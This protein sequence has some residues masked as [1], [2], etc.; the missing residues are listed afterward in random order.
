LLLQSDLGLAFECIE[1]PLLQRGMPGNKALRGWLV[2]GRE[3]ELHDTAD[4]H[5]GATCIVGIHGKDKC[6]W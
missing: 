2:K 4:T 1:L 3:R 5:F 6:I